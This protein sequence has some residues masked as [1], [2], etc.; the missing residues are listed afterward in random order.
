MKT[1]PNG[2]TYLA[3]YNSEQS[4]QNTDLFIVPDKHYFLLGDNRDC[5]KDSR[6]LT[7]VGYVN[8]FNLVGKQK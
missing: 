6:F 2:K 7:S 1:L 5:S 8:E 4:L 3:V